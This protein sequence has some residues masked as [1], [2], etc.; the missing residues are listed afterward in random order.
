MKKETYIDATPEAGKNFYLSNLAG[1]LV[2]LNLL[3][4]KPTADYSG[5]P[6]LKPKQTITGKEAYQ[7]YMEHTLPYLEEVGGVI[8]FYGR[9]HSFLIG[10]DYE[11]WDAV[12][13]VKQKNKETFLQFASNKGYL[14]GIGHRVAALED[15]RLLPIQQADDFILNT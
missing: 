9:S 1:E 13:L 10:P 15:A 11:K 12:L 4:F 14:E 5:F 6:N 3:K 2:M 8:L 7:K